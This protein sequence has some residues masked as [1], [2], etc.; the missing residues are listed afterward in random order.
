MFHVFV[1]VTTTNDGR[2]GLSAG[3]IVGI[4][5]AAIILFIATVVTITVYC[6]NSKKHPSG[7]CYSDIFLRNN[8]TSFGK[9]LRLY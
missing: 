9:D 6:K 7:E 1:S 5:F 2:D 3:A 4:V 8:I